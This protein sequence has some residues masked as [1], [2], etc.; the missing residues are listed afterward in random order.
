MSRLLFSI[1]S[2]PFKARLAHVED[3]F[4][5]VHSS[6][7]VPHNFKFPFL[8]NMTLRSGLVTQETI[9]EE[10]GSILMF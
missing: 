7:V 5:R 6:F 8:G 4:G 3:D 2:N 1:V 10:M 9:A